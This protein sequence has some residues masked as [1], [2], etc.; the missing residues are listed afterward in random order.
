MT[1]KGFRIK[2][3]FGIHRYMLVYTGSF[4]F[5]QTILISQRKL[6][7]IKNRNTVQNNVTTVIMLDVKTFEIY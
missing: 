6:K 4:M 7:R 3:K 5:K 1:R 2:S